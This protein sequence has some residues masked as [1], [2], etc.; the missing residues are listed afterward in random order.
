[1]R[2]FVLTGVD[3]RPGYRLM[4][5]QIFFSSFHRPSVCTSSR[6]SSGLPVSRQIAWR[7]CAT[8]AVAAPLLLTGA[9]SIQADKHGENGD[10][11]H[12]KISTPLGGLNVRSK[13]VDVASLGL[14]QY[15]GSHILTK[16]QDN[17]ND[18]QVDLHMGFGP[19]QMRVKVVSLAT[20]DSPDKVLAFYRKA[21]G[22]YGDVVECDGKKA[23]GTPAVTKEGLGCD[24]HSSAHSSWNAKG[25]GVNINT[26]DHELKAG[27][28]H[29]Q[30][31]VGF[32]KS[33]SDETKFA[34]IS[35]ELPN[36]HSDEQT[37]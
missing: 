37:D 30:H 29:R 17:G 32:K 35:L 6:D 12:V 19:W 10:S 33:D 27:S 21:L 2:V 25:S 36:T 15:P 13:D 9:C 22:K 5:Q 31:I 8:L 20:S 26:D 28:Q 23:V 4:R 34:L 7:L 3:F 1:M 11:D 24:E 18:G 16:D 14:P